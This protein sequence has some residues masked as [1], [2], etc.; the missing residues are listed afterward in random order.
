MNKRAR[1]PLRLA[2]W[3]AGIYTVLGLLW[4]ALS[5]AVVAWWTGAQV[6]DALT[7]ANLG[8]GFGFVAV[9]G[10]ALFLAVR[11]ALSQPLEGSSVTSVP[12]PGD[13]GYK[14]WLLLVLAVAISVTGVALATYH[15]Q[16]GSAQRQA[17]EELT[18]SAFLKAGLLDGWLDERLG[19]ARQLA[20]SR[21]FAVFALSAVERQS[22]LA[23][24]Q[25]DH[26]LD[27]L[28]SHYDYRSAVLLDSDF[29]P[30]IEVGQ[31]LPLDVAVD[32]ALAEAWSSAQVSQPRL[33][34]DANGRP[35]VSWVV[36]VLDRSDEAGRVAALV[37]LSARADRL[38]P[39]LTLSGGPDA[40]STDAHVVVREAP[41]EATIARI[42]A[43]GG[44]II[45]PPEA[46][47]RLRA[48]LLEGEREG[49]AVAAFEAA[50]PAFI[51]GVQRLEP[52][53]WDLVLKR[54]LAGL[55]VL[56]R[57]QAVWMGGATLMVWL[58][59]LGGGA[60]L[61]RQQWLRRNLDLVQAH[62]EQDRLLG[63]FFDMPFVGMA[64]S[65]PGGRGWERV[66]TC[67]GE[68]LGYPADELARMDWDRLTVPE[69]RGCEVALDAAMFAGQR[70]GYEIE[71]R[72]LRHD[73]R[74]LVADIDVKCTRLPDGSVDRVVATFE[75]ITDRRD[76]EERRRL[77]SVVFENTREGV[78]ITDDTAHI[79]SVNRAFTELMGY[80]EDEVV[81]RTP[82]MFQSGRHDQT[83]Y[84]NMRRQLETEGY[85][86]GEIWNRRKNGEIF[87]E[88]QSITAVRDAQGRLTHY[89][90]VFADISREKASEAELDFLAHHD[91]LTELPNRRLLRVRLAHAVSL[92][93]RRSGHLA[94]LIID[95][96]RFK[97]INASQ[98]HAVGDRL[99]KIVA[100]RLQGGRRGTDTVAR[101][102]SD[103]FAILVE[104]LA[105]PD[106]AAVVAENVIREVGYSTDLGNG[107]ETEIAVTVGIAVYP[108]HGTDADTLLQQAST[109]LDRA[110]DDGRGS[111][112]YYSDEFTRAARERID[113]ST[114]LR[115]AIEQDRLEVHYQPQY[116]IRDG[117]LIGAEALLRWDEPGLGPV[118]PG[119][120][121]PVAEQTGL[122]VELGEWVLRRVLAQGQAWREAGH[123][124]VRLAVNVSALQFQRVAI[125]QQVADL[126][127]SH[128]YPARYLELE[129]TESALLSDPERARRILQRLRERGV[130]FAVDDFG[131]GYSSMAQLK[132]FQVDTLKVD[133]SFVDGL[134]AG[135]EVA[136]DRSI[137]RAIVALGHGLG[138]CVLA[139]GVETRDQLAA[140]RELGCD[141]YQG[142]LASRPVPAERFAALLA[143]GPVTAGD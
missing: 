9:S 54:D 17:E 73:G 87:P 72:L 44:L 84:A 64:I 89:V 57:Q 141:H 24:E 4:I 28:R 107:V 142:Y 92:M 61:W 23:R 110:K 81:G 60:M 77:A 128:A 35:L 42:D 88:L 31:E 48:E 106:D 138:L 111:Y 115:R 76:E 140:L 129:I 105:H 13:F 3:I 101:L 75:D 79:L 2:S 22:S 32:A 119:R 80:T 67:L 134:A 29:E 104:N 1:T 97:D 94:V 34:A 52:P 38:Q 86:Q 10:A 65:R 16:H 91:P 63:V 95:L 124:A 37:L 108:D 20:E 118:S 12:R 112:R 68:M 41:D 11:W 113:L 132:R 47:A 36:P 45:E 49:I 102:A 46:F 120:F 33:H 136:D 139:E 26:H 55:A 14:P 6:G 123:P 70:D 137:T 56:P 7:L 39:L 121:I 85:W 19:H 69:D 117:A 27:L 50:E 93:R 133:K 30:L 62:A 125:D 74:V 40:L 99:L 100:D 15:V 126:L 71:K 83:F 18:R 114:R 116:R 127:E 82:K 66:N 103:E 109:A 135:A 131:T 58:L 53:G 25:V 90:S 21:G 43:N 122:I 130:S 59:V 78:V 5:D 8:K 143:E 98:G 51:A 96:D